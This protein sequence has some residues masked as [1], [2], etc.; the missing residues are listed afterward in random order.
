V[1][2]RALQAR[3]TTSINIKHEKC[4]VKSCKFISNR[5]KQCKCKKIHL[6][7]FMQLCKTM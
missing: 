5:V 7:G 6:Y 4:C 2:C 1:P 3:V